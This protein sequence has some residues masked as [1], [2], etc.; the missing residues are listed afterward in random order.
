MKRNVASRKLGLCIAAAVGLGGV[1]LGTLAAV[2]AP[3]GAPSAQTEPAESLCTLEGHR[4]IRPDILLPG[5]TAEVTIHVRAT[6]PRQVWTQHWVYVL[7]GSDSIDEA[8]RAEMR[9]LVVDTIKLVAGKRNGYWNAVSMVSFDAQGHLLC[10][11]EIDPDKLAACLDRLAIG[12]GSRLDL[13]LR[14]A[15]DVMPRI[16]DF[17]PPLDPGEVLVEDV[18]SQV[19]IVISD[20]RTSDDCT[21]ASTAARTAK[22]A[23]AIIFSVCLGGDCDATCLRSIA[24]SDRYFLTATGLRAML[25]GPSCRD[26]G[27]TWPINVRR[28]DITTYL[29]VAADY[30]ADSA[31]PEPVLSPDG[32]Q[33]TWRQNFVPL[34]GLTMTYL[35][36]PSGIGT[37]A[38]TTAT[39]VTMQDNMDRTRQLMIPPGSVLV[40]NPPVYLPHLLLGGPNDGSSVSPRGTRLHGVH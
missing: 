2:A 29:T 13:G 10:E 15:V 39:V 6:C 40:L 1:A 14:A 25:A 16:R 21:A 30:V 17:R 32:Q 12:A 37:L 24:A 4:T 34:D 5:Q 11:I 35:I 9:A 28:M 23:G 33:L 8:A 3:A 20:G 7:D 19:L 31:E 22:Q 27:G 26:C 18:S 38:V 36:R